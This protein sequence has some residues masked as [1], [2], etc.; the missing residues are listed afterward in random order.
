MNLNYIEH[1]FLPFEA[2]ELLVG[3]TTAVK[4]CDTIF[5][6]PA[7]MK[8]LTTSQGDELEHLLESIP[9]LDLDTID[10]GRM[11]VGPPSFEAQI[12]PPPG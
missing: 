5:V 12:R 2:S 1:L 9:L 4:A 7:M 10:G 3:S 6:S 11:F 8:L